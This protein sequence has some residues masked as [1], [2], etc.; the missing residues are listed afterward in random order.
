MP[1]ESPMGVG[2]S[3]I[4]KLRFERGSTW[5]GLEAQTRGPAPSDLANVGW[6]A[7]TQSITLGF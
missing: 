3:F 4:H 5:N 2:R 1:K 7:D 6:F